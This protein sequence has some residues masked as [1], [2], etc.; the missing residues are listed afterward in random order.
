MGPSRPVLLLCSLGP[1]SASL[2]PCDA[3]K[4][5]PCLHQASPR[6]AARARLHLL[7]ARRL[8]EPAP[9]RWRVRS[10]PRSGQGHAQGHPAV[11][12]SQAACKSPDLGPWIFSGRFALATTGLGR[13]TRVPW[14]LS[15]PQSALSSSLGLGGGSGN[16]A[17]C[18]T[19]VETL[20][21]HLCNE[22]M[23]PSR[24]GW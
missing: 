12:L 17:C 5:Q 16:E 18:L 7:T 14:G 9:S 6:P 3:C 24:A 4:S 21:P 20:S 23:A 2:R 13:R 15:I 22:G 19:V 8:S 10:R 11:G 1:V